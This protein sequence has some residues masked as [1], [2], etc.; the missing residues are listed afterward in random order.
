MIQEA[1]A[2]IGTGSDIEDVAPSQND[3]QEDSR[4]TYP[5]RSC[6]W[7]T[8]SP[9]RVTDADPGLDA[10]FDGANLTVQEPNK[11]RST[12]LILRRRPITIKA[13]RDAGS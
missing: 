13:S 1:L 7:C 9:Q 12:S 6:P 5:A 4:Q 10:K 8:C 3:S 2:A 11:S